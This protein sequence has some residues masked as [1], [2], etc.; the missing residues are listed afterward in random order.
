[1]QGLLSGSAGALILSRFSCQQQQ[2]QDLV[3]V[4]IGISILFICCQSLKIVPDL[5][6]LFACPSQSEVRHIFK[7]IKT[8]LNDTTR[9]IDFQG[10][11]TDVPWTVTFI[12]NISHLLVCVNSAANFLFYFLHGAKFRAAFKETFLS[13]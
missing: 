4:L 1:M 3:R 10:G 9:K 13:L 7:F 5:Y 6:E 11:C 12:M 2:G 8:I